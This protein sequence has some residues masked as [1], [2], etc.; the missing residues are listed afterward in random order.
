ME[1]GGAGGHDHPIDLAAFDVL[2]DKLLA[3]VR[4]HEHIGVR[5]ND[6]RDFLDLLGDPTHV[7]VVG[8]VAAAVA[9]IDTDAFGALV[10]LL[11]V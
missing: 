9:D 2:L 10:L 3:R 4:T 8:D 5:H 6:T 7:H 1:A 11:A